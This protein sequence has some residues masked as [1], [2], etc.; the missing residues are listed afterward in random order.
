[1]NHPRLNPDYK[2]KERAIFDLGHIAHALLLEGIDKIFE[3]KAD[4][5]RTKAAQEERNEAR[6][7]GMI[8]LLSENAD[9]AREM[10]MAAERQLRESDLGIQNLREEGEAELSYI[11]QEQGTWMKVRPDWTKN[12]RTLCLDL[13]TTGVSA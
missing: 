12:N 4:S 11:W 2:P 6:K 3:I 9:N 8:P 1:M 13:K 7:Q 10:V 5:W